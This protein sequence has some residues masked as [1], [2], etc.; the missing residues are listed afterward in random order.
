[1]ADSASSI[2]TGMYS[3]E[4]TEDLFER[5]G[6][7]SDS[8][9]DMVQTAR[10]EQLWENVGLTSCSESETEEEQPLRCPEAEPEQRRR[11]QLE[12]TVTIPGVQD[13]VSALDRLLFVP[14][15]A[16][17][18]RRRPKAKAQPKEKAAAVK[19]QPSTPARQKAQA[20]CGSS[21][22]PG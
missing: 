2:S 19:P 1:M 10:L 17:P 14:P 18:R 13:L 6:L 16:A 15:T 22:S 11:I 4:D 20:R 12:I 5:L 8:G 9:D 3:S 7:D 21:K